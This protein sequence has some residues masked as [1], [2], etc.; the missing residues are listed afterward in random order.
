MR[1]MIFLILLGAVLLTGCSND[2]DT[3]ELD[4]NSGS[5]T[6][7]F[8]IICDPPDA[9]P[10][11]T[12]AVT[13]RFYE[14]DPANVTVIWQLALD[15][16]DDI[17]GDQESEDGIVD[18]HEIALI[19]APVFDEN[20]VGEQTFE[21]VVPENTLLVSNGLVDVYDADLPPALA[22]LFGQAT[23]G[24]LTRAELD[25]FFSTCDPTEYDGETLAILQEISGYFACQIRLRAKIRSGISL[26]VTKNMTVR[27]SRKLGSGNI[28]HN[29]VIDWMALLSVHHKDVD[30][31][32][33]VGNYTCDTTYVWHGDP[34][35]METDPIPV[36][37]NWTYYLIVRHR[38][39]MYVS[40]AGLTHEEDH[41]SDWY[42]LR[43]DDTATSA[44]FME[45]ESG[46]DAHMSSGE[47]YVQVTP[48]INEASRRIRIFAVVRDFRY[49]WELFN[50]APGGCYETVVLEFET[51]AEGP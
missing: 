40:P 16:T 31:F 32:D 19:P 45:E 4:V 47:G 2:F 36:K 51:P 3:N 41:S 38:T 37:R 18:L 30:D 11:E 24:Q 42:Y 26:D 22:E 13:L 23:P 17:Y 46:H 44:D 27:Y 35:Q 20:G 33:D 10:G 48:P 28:N 8:T 34:E 43:L 21:F 14:P 5:K 39:E 9:S 49:E 1:N 25:A 15:Y 29:P 50:A 7:P 6:R 12:V